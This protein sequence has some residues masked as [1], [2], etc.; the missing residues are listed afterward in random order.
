MPKV[1]QNKPVRRGDYITQPSKLDNSA[2]AQKVSDALREA[3]TE[4]VQPE[5][6]LRR[7]LYPLLEPKGS[8]QHI[9]LAAVGPLGKL[10]I[11]PW[12]MTKGAWQK[13]VASRAGYSGLPTELDTS[14]I[15]AS[16]F[17]KGRHNVRVKNVNKRDWRGPVY[18]LEASS[19]RTASVKEAKYFADY[20]V[21]KQWPKTRVYD[22]DVVDETK[23]IVDKRYVPEEKSP[24]FS[25]EKSEE[26]IYRGMSSNEFENAVNDGYIQSRGALNFSD[27]EGLT[28][29]A[30]NPSQAGSYAGNFA[31]W[32]S[33]PSWE[34]PG[35]VVKV[36][37]PSKVE[38]NQVGEIG[39]RGKVPIDDIES[40][41]EMRVATE[42]PGEFELVS[43][44]G[45]LSEGSGKHISQS[46]V[47]RELPKSEWKKAFH[48]RSVEGAISKGESV[49]KEVLKEYGLR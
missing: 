32:H 16:R 18:E 27:Q 13:H 39:V 26:S 28:L 15:F 6:F 36:K 49:P 12:Q 3:V 30:D 29:F 46:Y 5:A 47:V 44:Y 11:R 25:T 40:V 38:V 9:D 4:Y 37:R 1:R 21:D 41:W 24:I 42:S 10:P 2:K 22:S 31:P 33:M 7:G 8:K 20:D 48:Q 19:P 45:E 34:Q 43:N 17:L 35:I 14:T 23:K